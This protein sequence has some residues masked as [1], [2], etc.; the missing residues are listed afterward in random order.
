MINNDY[1]TPA[2]VDQQLSTFFGPE[3]FTDGKQRPA[4]TG[5]VQPRVGL[6]WDLTGKG[7]SVL[8]GGWGR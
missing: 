5:A 8:F 2:L 7:E 4:F 6:A 3:F 1:V